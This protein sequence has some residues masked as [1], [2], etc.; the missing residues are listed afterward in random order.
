MGLIWHIRTSGRSVLLLG[1]LGCRYL[2]LNIYLVSNAMTTLNWAIVLHCLCPV[3]SS[4]L[5][6]SCTDT[7]APRPRL[8]IPAAY[9]KACCKAIQ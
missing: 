4:I 2:G 5:K 1:P 9:R 7:R 6:R 8:L 3:S